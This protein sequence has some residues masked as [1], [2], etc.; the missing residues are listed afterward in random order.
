MA[1][2][3]KGAEKCLHHFFC[4]KL[5]MMLQTIVMVQGVTQNRV[6]LRYFTFTGKL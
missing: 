2:S 3:D 4:Y 6:L 1:K 5:A